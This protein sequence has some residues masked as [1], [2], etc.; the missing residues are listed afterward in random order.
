VNTCLQVNAA[1]A[2][3]RANDIIAIGLRDQITK[4]QNQLMDC[5]DHC[6]Q[7]VTSC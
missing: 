6:S 4:L 5:Q 2:E 7:Q 3:Y 1:T